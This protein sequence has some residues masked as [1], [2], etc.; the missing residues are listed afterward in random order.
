MSPIAPVTEG[1]VLA[2]CDHE[3]KSRWGRCRRCRNQLVLVRIH[4]DPPIFIETRGQWQYLALH[5][6][7][8]LAAR[9]K[10]K[11]GTE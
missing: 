1:D 10:E 5:R 7:L 6:L 9:W 3:P 2:M 8:A 11:T 4:D